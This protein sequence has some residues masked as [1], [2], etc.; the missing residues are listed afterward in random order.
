M[1]NKEEEE[2]NTHWF[3]GAYWHVTIMKKLVGVSN[4]INNKDEQKL[5][6]LVLRTKESRRRAKLRKHCI[7]IE[8]KEKT[9]GIHAFN[10]TQLIQ[11][12]L[13]LVFIFMTTN[14]PAV[15]RNFC[16]NLLP[17]KGRCDHKNMDYK[18]SR[19]KKK[20]SEVFVPSTIHKT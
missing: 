13:N 17:F 1:K 10:N 9:L 11:Y 5:Q 6:L 20:K 7:T 16:W 8:E 4:D 18:A 2:E 15:R 12:F 19:W 14:K 3:D